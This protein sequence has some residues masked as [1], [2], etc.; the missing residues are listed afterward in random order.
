VEGI[1]SNES[2]HDIH[3]SGTVAE[4]INKINMKIEFQKKI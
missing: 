4:N 3:T 1:N 2:E